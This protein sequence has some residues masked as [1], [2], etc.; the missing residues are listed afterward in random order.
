MTEQSMEQATAPRFAKTTVGGFLG[1]LASA[2]PTPGGGA[3]AA[4]VGALGAGLV[5]MVCHLTVGRP[6]YAEVEAE[7]Q[8]VLAQS[9]AA[10]QRLT[11]LADAD[12]AAFTVVSAAY[13]LPKST[14]DERAVRAEAI[15]RALIRAAEPPLAVMRECRALIPLC[16]KVAARGNA[17]V[18]SDAGVAVELAAAGLRSS[19]LNV[20]VNLAQIKDAVFVAQGEASIQAAEAGLRDEIDRTIGIVRAKLAPRGKP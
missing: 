6:R 17:T 20:T 16:L 7:I 10:G 4:L 13:R 1:E 12:A 11:A 2:A 9:E 15:E 3:A 18:V 8:D 14:A 5:S 19:I